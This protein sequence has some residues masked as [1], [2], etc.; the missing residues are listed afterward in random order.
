MNLRLQKATA[1]PDVSLS[2]NYDKLGSY[3]NNFIGAGIAF[4]LPFFNRNQGN[5]KQA[6]IAIDQSQVQFQSQQDQVESDVATD[7]KTAL[8]LEKLYSS[9][10]P[11]FKDDFTH[12]IQEVYLNYEKR[13]LSML[14]FLDFYDSYKTNTLQLNNLQLNRVIS[15]EQLNYATGTLFFNQQ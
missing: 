11:K 2:L 14:E 15:L 12:L 6:Q 13:N 5:I 1:V 4:S 9:F 3:S 7:Y 8:R 10:D